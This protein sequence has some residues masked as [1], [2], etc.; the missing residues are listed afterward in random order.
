MVTAMF[1][2]EKSMAADFLILA[3][4]LMAQDV[5]SA[6]QTRDSRITLPVDSAR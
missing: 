4:H 1:W 6:V 2:C 5:A 3:F